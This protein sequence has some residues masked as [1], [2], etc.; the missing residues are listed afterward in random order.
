MSSKREEEARRDYVAIVA[1]Y[2][3]SI[4]VPDDVRDVSTAAVDEKKMHP[5]VSV[6]SGSPAR[7]ALIFEED[8][9]VDLP[10]TLEGKNA[11]VNATEHKTLRE[12]FTMVTFRKFIQTFLS[13]IFEVQVNDAHKVAYGMEAKPL[14]DDIK[15]KFESWIFSDGEV[16]VNL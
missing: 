9:N 15:K 1:K 8:D 16:S 5:G 13:A 11:T 4:S 2:N 3:R 6:A 12:Q 14:N 10:V 7:N